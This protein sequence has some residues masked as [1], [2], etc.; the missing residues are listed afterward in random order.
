[1]RL[2]ILVRLYV[3]VASLLVEKRMTEMVEG[4]FIREDVW[5]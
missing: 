1:M 2:Y 4:R 5:L 3:E